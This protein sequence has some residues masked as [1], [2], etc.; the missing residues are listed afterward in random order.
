MPRAADHPVNGHWLEYTGH[1]LEL[2]SHRLEY[3]SHWLEYTGH[4]AEYTLQ[5]MAG[6]RLVN[7]VSSVRQ[8]S[9]PVIWW[10]LYSNR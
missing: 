9:R 2:S 6:K 10:S 5:S 3:T 8:S 1:W 4:R 7:G